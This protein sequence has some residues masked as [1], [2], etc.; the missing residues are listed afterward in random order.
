MVRVGLCVLLFILDIS[1][2]VV[3]F[4][5]CVVGRKASDA[6]GVRFLKTAPL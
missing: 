4:W 3:W 5:V 2:A 1:Y 6:S